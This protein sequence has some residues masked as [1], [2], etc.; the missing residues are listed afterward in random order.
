MS[1]SNVSIFLSKLRQQMNP[2]LNIGLQKIDQK[3]YFQMIVEL[4]ENAFLELFRDLQRESSWEVL[5]LLHC[6]ANNLAIQNPCPKSSQGKLYERTKY[7][8]AWAI[9][10]GYIE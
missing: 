9:D 3:E 1:N 4:G 5:M 2:V 10:N 7:W 8:I 6:I